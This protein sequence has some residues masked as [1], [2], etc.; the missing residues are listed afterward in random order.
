MM[1]DQFPS[2]AL[3]RHK[4]LNAALQ[5]NFGI[6]SRA[7][8]MAQKEG[9]VSQATPAPQLALVFWSMLHGFIS[10]ALSNASGLV[11]NTAVSLNVL[12]ELCLESVLKGI[13]P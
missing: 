6:L 1:F 11:R 8:E 2:E 12:E 4:A 5:N 9:S 7:M 3:E 10:L 13:A